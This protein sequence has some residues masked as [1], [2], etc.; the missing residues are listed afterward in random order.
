MQTKICYSVQG[1]TNPYK[2][3]SGQNRTDNPPLTR[4]KTQNI[5][6]E[7]TRDYVTGSS[8]TSS[9]PSSK[10]EFSPLDDELYELL[11]KLTKLTPDQ[12]KAVAVTLCNIEIPPEMAEIVTVWP[13]LP[14]HIKQSI[15]ALV[16]ASVSPVER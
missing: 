9:T 14:E 15:L 11:D 8:D 3:A 1:N 6:A 12:R 5:S 7:K 13:K 16:R 10:N 2:K 4:R